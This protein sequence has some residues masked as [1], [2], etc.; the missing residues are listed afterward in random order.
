MPNYFTE[1]TEISNKL[2]FCDS[3]WMTVICP[4]I[5]DYMQ[6]ITLKSNFQSSGRRWYMIASRR[7]V[8]EHEDASL[9]HLM[10]FFQSRKL[11]L[12]LVAVDF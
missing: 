5:T 6:L 10:I 3:N 12:K 11:Q 8:K 9:K 2:P 7:A 1:V 4:P